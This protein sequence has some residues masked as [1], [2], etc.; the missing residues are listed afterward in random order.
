MGGTAQWVLEDVC[1]ILQLSTKKWKDALK[2]SEKGVVQLEPGLAGSAVRAKEA[3]T[4]TEEG[5]LRLAVRARSPIAK[6]FHEWCID[7]RRLTSTGKVKGSHKSHFDDTA[8]FGHYQ[9]AI[10]LAKRDLLR[11]YDHHSMWHLKQLSDGVYCYTENIISKH[12]NKASPFLLLR[13][14]CIMQARPRVV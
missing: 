1:A 5:L 8:V 4:C 10:E 3:V 13:G 14:E 2:P 9:H 7:R 11:L 6:S 12:K